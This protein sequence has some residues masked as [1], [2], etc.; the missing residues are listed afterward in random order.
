MLRSSATRR[1][2]LI[3]SS[4]ATFPEVRLLLCRQ[5]PQLQRQLHGT[6]LGL[7]L[8]QFKAKRKERHSSAA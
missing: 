7:S 5:H 6:T 1:V 4:P 2:R 8:P 3:D